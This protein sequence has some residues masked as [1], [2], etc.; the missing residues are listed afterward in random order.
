MSEWIVSG[1]NRYSIRRAT[2]DGIVA[3]FVKIIHGSHPKGFDGLQQFLHLR[4]E[5]A[6]QIGFKSKL[7]IRLQVHP[8]IEAEQEVF[9]HSCQ[10]G[11]FIG[12]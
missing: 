12:E 2:G 3:F 4:N 7:S 11:E 6:S 1:K 8:Y 5:L 9:L 10:V